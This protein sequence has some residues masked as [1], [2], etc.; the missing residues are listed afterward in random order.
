MYLGTHVH[1]VVELAS[2]D[3]LTV[4]QPNISSDLPGEDTPLYL[5]W[6]LNDCL[7]LPVTGGR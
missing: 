1:Y 3:R 2:G 7:A 6:D 4:M 5:A